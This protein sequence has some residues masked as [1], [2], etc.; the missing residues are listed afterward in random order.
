M[1]GVFI[2]FE[3]TEGSGKSTH[4]AHVVRR[5]AALKRE[6][7]ATREPG[8]TPLGERIRDVIKHDP[9][10]NGMSAEAETLLFQTSRAELVRRV[11][12]PAIERGAVVICDRFTDSTL[13]YQGAGRGLNLGQLAAV[14]NFATGGLVP[15]LTI[16]MD[17]DVDTSLRRMQERNEKAGIP[18]DRIEAEDRQFH[19]RIRQG[20]LTLA[21][22]NPG[23][24]KRVDAV[25]SFDTVAAEVWRHVGGCIGAGHD[26]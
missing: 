21:T 7:I 8:G 10:A 12:R 17:V 20:F 15:N 16:L 19:E 11:I 23:R 2:T 4:A 13:A 24:I 14:C 25:G 22:A 3:G 5:I 1:A 18:T 26:A 9:S 6:V